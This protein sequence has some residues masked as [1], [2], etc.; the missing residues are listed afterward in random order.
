VASKENQIGSDESPTPP[1][2]VLWIA[3]CLVVTALAFGIFLQKLTR[4]RS[5]TEA[6]KTV[7]QRVAE[8]GPGVD[9][10]LAPFFREKQVAYPPRSLV[11][12]G[13]KDEKR[14]EVYASSNANQPPRFIRAYP[15]LGA[16]G[17]A[18]PKL[19]EGD[20]QVPEGIYKIESLNPN[21]LYHLALR[22][23]YPNEWD[24][25]QAQREGRANLGGDIMI[26]GSTGSIGCL[27]MGDEAAED[28][29]VLAAKTGIESIRVLLCPTDFRKR[30][31]L[32]PDTGAMPVWI[33]EVYSDLRR[34]LAALPLPDERAQ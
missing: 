23:N 4:P 20:L 33:S 16:S 6:A 11:F 1:V 3:L 22:V 25:A 24:R 18:G 19:R 27:A 2:H 26:H 9:A 8:F 17:N 13:L 12:V 29:F 28:L 15:I 5:R 7:A 21:S 30:K 34:D 14:L 10:R 32:P 31:S